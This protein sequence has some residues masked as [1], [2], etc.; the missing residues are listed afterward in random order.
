MVKPT[1]L[2]ST[3][4]NGGVNSSLKAWIAAA[5]MACFNSG[6]EYSGRPAQY[7]SGHRKRG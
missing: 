6:G 2:N 5:S 4:R 3:A 7:Q 1:H